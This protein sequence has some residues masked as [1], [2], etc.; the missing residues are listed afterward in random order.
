MGAGRST[1][2]STCPLKEPGRRARHS[3]GAG[4]RVLGQFDIPL[5]EGAEQGLLVRGIFA[6]RADADA[7]CFGEAV[8]RG[9]EALAP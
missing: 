9:D 8:G 4:R 1:P 6:P 7:G 5:G 2:I 3:R